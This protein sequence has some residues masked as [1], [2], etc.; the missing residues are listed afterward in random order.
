MGEKIVINSWRWFDLVAF[1]KK[2]YQVLRKLEQKV[3]LL[4]KQH[5]ELM[6]KIEK[7]Q[8][9]VTPSYADWKPAEWVCVPKESDAIFLWKKILQILRENI[10]RP[11]FD[12]WFVPTEAIYIRQNTLFVLSPNKFSCDWL[13]TQY[14][15]QI[16]TILKKL[17]S[18]VKTVQFVTYQEDFS[19]P[20]KKVEIHELR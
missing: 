5:D 17:D 15:S 3:D 7:Q 10:P 12:T 16:Q 13:H 9:E 8:R 20:K 6:K 14:L 4:T 19:K 18:K 2:T 11:S 1:S